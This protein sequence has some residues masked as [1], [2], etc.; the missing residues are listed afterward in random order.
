[1]TCTMLHC[2]RPSF[3]DIWRVERGVCFWPWLII[4]EDMDSDKVWRFFETQCIAQQYTVTKHAYSMTVID[5]CVLRG[6][7]GRACDIQTR[8][9]FQPSR[10][11]RV[12]LWAVIITLWWEIRGRSVGHEIL[13]EYVRCCLE[14][15]QLIPDSGSCSSTLRRW[16]Y[17]TET[18]DCKTFIWRG[19]DG[20]DNR[21][22]SRRQCERRCKGRSA[23]L[24]ALLRRM[25]HDP[26]S[27][28][29]FLVPETWAENLGHVPW[30]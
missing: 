30:A 16:Y 29:K 9:A 12:R 27:P 3:L 6:R 13:L 18:G 10:L 4:G 2:V 25:A 28:A 14:Q 20:N 23:A 8:D 19:C 24:Y 7:H 21:F 5:A 15:C 17:D 11:T 1:M 26:S 22:R